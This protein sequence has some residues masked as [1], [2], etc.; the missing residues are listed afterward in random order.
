V[1]LIHERLGVCD[2]RQQVPNSVQGNIGRI[3]KDVNRGSG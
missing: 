3:R 2:A 1:L